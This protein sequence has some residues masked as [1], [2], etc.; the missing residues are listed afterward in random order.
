MF[1]HHCT[2]LVVALW[3]LVL[4]AMP[5]AAQSAASADQQQP[6]GQTQGP[7]ILEPVSHRVVVVPDV[8][9]SEVDG[10]SATLVGGYGGMVM[11]DHLLVGG[12]G[13]WL[14]NNRW[15][16]EMFYLGAVVGWY[17]LGSDRFDI[18]LSSLVGGGTG[19]AALDVD[20]PVIMRP[21]DIRFGRD[22]RPGSPTHLIWPSP[23]V[24][25]RTF[26]VAEPTASVIW[27]FARRVGITGSVSYRLVGGADALNEAFRGVSGSVGIV[28]GGGK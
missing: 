16:R 15:D 6:G 10:R 21:D 22:Q 23:F 12:G 1:R 9:F 24:M 28:F 17:L 27:R 4:A 3:A 13:Y 8:R 19:T 20:G 14:A 18:S 2:T 25:Q 11:D 7:M 26:F 5:A